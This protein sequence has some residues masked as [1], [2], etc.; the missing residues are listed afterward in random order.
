MKTVKVVGSLMAAAVLTVMGVGVYA[1]AGGY[2][3]AADRTHWPATQRLLAYVRDSAVARRAR[4]LA[5]PD[6]ADPAMI[7]TGAAH[8]Q[9]MCVDCHLAPGLGATELSAGLNPRPPDF[10]PGIAT[11]AQN[12]RPPAEQFWIIKHGIRMSGMPAWGNTHDDES[13]WAL[14]AFLR[15][16]PS[17]DEAS[18]AALTAS[19][20]AGHEHGAGEHPHGHDAESGG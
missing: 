18:Y 17:L 5:V 8:Y 3:V 1:L 20:T 13:L 19:G 12:A 2:D 4:S 14:V 9:A 6:L 15:Q 11:S 10:A 7:R 16:L